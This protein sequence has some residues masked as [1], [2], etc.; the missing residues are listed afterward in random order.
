MSKEI[1]EN[2]SR[3]LSAGASY[4]LKHQVLSP[5]EVLGQ[6]IANIAPTATPTVVIPLVFASAGNATWAAYLFALVG[7]LLVSLNINVFARRSASPGSLYTYIS[8][9][10]GS[11]WGIAIGWTLFVA[12]VTCASS[13][14]TGFTSY[15]NVLIKDLF[16]RT[17]DL[18]PLVLVGILTASVLGAWLVAYKDI[19][20]STRL[21]LGFELVSVAFIVVVV[22]ATLLHGGPH[23]DWNQL[24]F[25][26]VSLNGLRLG[27]VLAI[28]SFTGF[29]SATALGSEAQTPL[30][31]VPRAVR[32][33]AIFVG[34]LFVVAAY[35]QVL[36]FSG[37]EV[38]LDKSDAPLQ[39]LAVKSGI[40]VFG[41][42]ITVGAI[43]SF[44]ACVLASI[45]AGGRIL[46]L[47]SRHGVFHESIGGAHKKNETPHVAVT[48]AALLAFVPA[49]ILTGF[50]A[51]LFSIYGWIGTT[52]TLSFIVAY[53]AVSVAA[54]VYLHRR[55]ELRF[56][57]IFVALASVILQLFVLIWA[58]YPL[59]AAPDSYPIYAF[60]GL[61]ALGIVAGFVIRFGSARVHGLI[62]DDVAAIQKRFASSSEI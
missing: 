57:N 29:E 37:N 10:L 23:L 16:G 45:T 42:L 54:P 27:L 41:V 56:G 8:S 36:G 58:T 43:I 13:V 60:L 5:L 33:S 53:I 15:A 7:I 4:G 31:T 6:S 34:L 38:P 50:G 3:S 48:I 61:L 2:E 49:A 59:P 62:T 20:L 21:M 51:N 19:R 30:K 26:G 40:P 39:V 44:F 24:S 9:S 32:R 18:P 28:F 11:A 1:S 55:G 35:A 25:K 46:F 17:Q 47:M 14:T 52:A 12:Y 22:A